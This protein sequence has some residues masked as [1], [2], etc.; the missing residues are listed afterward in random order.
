MKRKEKRKNRNTVKAP[1]LSKESRK[2]AG[3]R[4]KGRSI[5]R[6]IENGK[7]E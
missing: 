4:G 6:Q 1:K 7:K 3:E 2:E 5:E